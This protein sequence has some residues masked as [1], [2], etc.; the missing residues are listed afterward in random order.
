MIEELSEKYIKDL[1]EIE[2]LTFS[3]PWSEKAF[4]DSLLSPFSHFFVF[5]ENGKAIGYAGLYAISGEGSV[6]NVATH[7][8]ARGRGVARA[9]LKR[10]MEEAR[11]LS[12]EFISLEVRESNEVARHLYE[13]LGFEAMGKRKNFYSKPREDAIVMNYFLKKDD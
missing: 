1:A 2:R 3:D 13:S 9:L 12:L 7:P 5:V 4:K 8:S 6:T 11:T 10:M